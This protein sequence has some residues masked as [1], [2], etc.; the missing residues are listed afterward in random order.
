MIALAQSVDNVAPDDAQAFIAR[1]Q[2]KVD[3]LKLA[4][5]HLGEGKTSGEGERIEFPAARATFSNPP[6]ARTWRGAG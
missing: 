5:F 4:L 1:Y 6:A 2:R 3:A